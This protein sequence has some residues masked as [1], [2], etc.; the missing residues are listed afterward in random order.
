[1]RIRTDNYM[2]AAYVHTADSH[3]R[4]PQVCPISCGLGFVG[5]CRGRTAL[6]FASNPT[7]AEL[8]F[9]LLPLD[10]KQQL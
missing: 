1:M 7:T 9:R 6:A 10:V 3:F 4:T 8:V 5:L 2:S